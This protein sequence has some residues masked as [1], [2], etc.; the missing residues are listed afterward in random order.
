MFRRK[1][2]PRPEITEMYGDVRLERLWLN[3]LMEMNKT[4]RALS[5]SC[6]SM[7]IPF[8]S[9]VKATLVISLDATLRGQN[10]LFSL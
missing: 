3:T 2:P 6:L 8:F 4:L 5:F 7:A 9:R 1:T 10:F